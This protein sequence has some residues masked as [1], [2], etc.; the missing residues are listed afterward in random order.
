MSNLLRLCDGGR[1]AV[2]LFLD[3]PLHAKLYLIY[4]SDG[5]ISGFVGSSNLTASGLGRPGELN[6]EIKDSNLGHSLSAWF[7]DLW[8]SQYSLDLTAHLAEIIGQELSTSVNSTPPP[9]MR[10]PVHQKAT[11]A[12]ASTNDAAHPSMTGHQLLDRVSYHATEWNRYKDPRP[13]GWKI[14]RTEH[15][16][17]LEDQWERWK[18]FLSKLSARERASFEANQHELSSALFRKL[19]ADESPITRNIDLYLYELHKEYDDFAGAQVLRLYRTQP[20]GPFAQEMAIEMVVREL[21]VKLSGS[22]PNPGDPSTA[23]G[24]YVTSREI[25]NREIHTSELLRFAERGRYLNSLTER[26]AAPYRG[27]QKTSI[28]RGFMRS[29]KELWRR[30]VFLVD[31]DGIVWNPVA[32]LAEVLGHASFGPVVVWRNRWDRDGLEDEVMTVADVVTEMQGVEVPVSSGSLDEM[33]RA[34]VRAHRQGG[35]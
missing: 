9:E 6:V 12:P 2:R 8:R 34:L 24:L 23:S 28:A 4:R 21:I 17:I 7:N 26:S 33:M 30:C 10:S 27:N 5:L 25:S 35:M 13:D 11:S 20:A 22:S 31:A 19:T 32:E 18:T 14:P 29:L 15:R 16:V 3:Y 1:L